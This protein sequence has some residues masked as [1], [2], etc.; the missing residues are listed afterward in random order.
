M[1]KLL[2]VCCGIMATTAV[3]SAQTPQTPANPTT[4]STQTTTTRQ[5]SQPVTITGCVTPDVTSASATSTTNPRFMLSNIQPTVG[6][7]D[8]SRNSAVTSYILMPGA[9]V[10]LGDHLNHKVQITGTVDSSSTTTSSSSQTSSPSTTATTSSS[11]QSASAAVP[12]FR[13]TSVKMLSET[14][15]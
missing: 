3:L 1:K 13:V 15:P 12:S 14:C 11:T 9:D 2:S 4:S 5:A 8:A 10:N 6:T 7:S